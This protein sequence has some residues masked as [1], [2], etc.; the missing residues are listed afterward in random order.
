M[1]D[2]IAFNNLEDNIKFELYTNAMTDIVFLKGVINELTNK[3][4][5]QR[6]YTGYSSA[7]TVTQQPQV[8][9]GYTGSQRQVTNELPQSGKPPIHLFLPRN[10]DGEALVLGDS[11]TNR[12]NSDQVGPGV[13][14]RGFGGAKIAD[15][16]Q[17]VFGSRRKTFKHVSLCVGINDVLSTEFNLDVAIVEMEKL[18][19]IVNDK[20]APVNISI[21]TLTPL[22]GL[23]KNAN[24]NISAFNTGLAG[25]VSRLADISIAIIDMHSAFSKNSSTLLA[26]DG[27][28]P[29]ID[30]LKVIVASHRD[31]LMKN[32]IQIS[33]DNISMRDRFAKAPS[34][35]K[36]QDT[37]V[38][39]MKNFINK[40]GTEQ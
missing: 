27:I 37:I 14:T 8:T 21:A 7:A 15:I 5:G 20:F 17:R 38:S 9:T 28:H 11:I 36:T 4:P 30:G 3:I 32:N 29:N 6:T 23:Q 16:G 24:P 31:N 39:S 10:V 34:R 19:H 33:N 35:D 25:L 26:S 1:L 12:I 40:Y 18:V 22:G 2:Q 13:I